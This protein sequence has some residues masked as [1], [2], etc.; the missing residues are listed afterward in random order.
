MA[1]TLTDLVCTRCGYADRADLHELCRRGARSAHGQGP[2]AGDALQAST[3]DSRGVHRQSPLELLDALLGLGQLAQR[4]LAG[5]DGAPPSVG[6]VQHEA[7][8][9][10]EAQGVCESTESGGELGVRLQRDLKHQPEHQLRCKHA[11]HR[12]GESGEVDTR[13]MVPG[14][15]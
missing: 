14:Q 15:F 9:R 3:A 12:P 8:H 2:A 4:A 13:L 6:D 7:S 1:I 11:Q 10:D 5:E